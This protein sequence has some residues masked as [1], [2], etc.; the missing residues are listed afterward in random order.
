MHKIN[1]SFFNI[2]NQSLLLQRDVNST[3][4][5]KWLIL[6]SNI[7]KLSNLHLKMGPFV[8]PSLYWVCIQSHSRK[9]INELSFI[10]YLSVD[11]SLDFVRGNM[12]QKSWEVNCNSKNN[13]RLAGEEIP[14]AFV[15]IYTR[16]EVFMIK[17]YIWVFWVMVLWS[18]NWL[19]MFWRNILSPYLW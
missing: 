9:A 12:E 14:R 13:N 8:W 4:G 7:R 16:F 18:G 10:F 11:T 1:L 15:E 5:W 3:S 17:I 6:N 19:L 2:W